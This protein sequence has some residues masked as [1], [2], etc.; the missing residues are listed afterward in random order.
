MNPLR[1]VGNTPG[2]RD[3]LRRPLGVRRPFFLDDL[4]R[5][6]AVPS[7]LAIS[8]RALD[9]PIRIG[10]VGV[11]SWG[12]NLLRTLAEWG[13][14]G[15]IVEIDPAKREAL[16]LAHPGVRVCRSLLDLFD[17]D[18]TAVAVAT[19]A[20][21]HYAIARDALE[22]GKDVFV[23]KPLTLSPR[24]AEHLVALAHERGTILMVGH[25]LLYHPAVQWMKVFL[26]DGGLGKIHSLHQRR[27][28]LGRLQ[29]SEN[30]LWDLGVHDVAVVLHLIDSPLA[31]MTFEGHGQVRPSIED[32]M[33]LHL[34]FESGVRAHLHTSWLWP[35]KERR[36]TIVGERGMMVYDELAQ[37][38]TLHHR[39]VD[40]N[41]D[42][43]DRGKEIVF[44]DAGDPLRVE[45]D[46]FLRR[47][48]DRRAPLSDGRSALEVV[49]VLARASAAAEA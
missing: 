7:S 8:M 21:T 20:A 19:P 28:M 36:L 14:L 25:I 40:G 4:V 26:R 17:D 35:D 37:T 18:V 27:L 16:A 22:A 41:L 47:V 24:E 2:D 33:Y 13:S 39:Y 49:R 5:A 38:V 46:H 15:A 31:G 43:V 32:D 10:L 3:L 42:G 45:L 23:E 11:G 29:R 44:S 9:R 34:R 12:K 6:P 30:V 1:R 48:Q